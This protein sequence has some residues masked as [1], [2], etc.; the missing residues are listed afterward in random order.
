MAVYT[1]ILSK[2]VVNKIQQHGKM[3][4]YDDPEGF[5]PWTQGWFGGADPLCT[6]YISPLHLEGLLYYLP[7]PSEVE[8]SRNKLHEAGLLFTERH[9]VTTEALSLGQGPPRLRKTV[10]GRLNL[11]Y[12]CPT[13]IAAEGGQKAVCPRGLY[14]GSHMTHLAKH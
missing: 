12:T 3:I 11:V 9:Q 4:T 7:E 5:T 1:K 13:C 10:W 6:G 14:L 8:H 2:V